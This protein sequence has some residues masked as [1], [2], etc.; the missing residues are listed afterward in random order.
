LFNLVISDVISVHVKAVQSIGVK[1]F[2][3]NTLVF[4][5]CLNHSLLNH[6]LTHFPTRT[7]II[8]GVLQNPVQNVRAFGA[9]K[10]LAKPPI[11]IIFNRDLLTTVVCYIF[12]FTNGP[13]LICPFLLFWLLIWLTSTDIGAIG[14]STDRLNVKESHHFVFAIM[15]LDEL[16]NFLFDAW[17]LGYV[18]DVWAIVLFFAQELLDQQFNVVAGAIRKGVERFVPD[19]VEEASHVFVFKWLAKSNQFVHN[20]SHCPHVSLRVI[21]EVVADLGRHKVWSSTSGFSHIHLTFQGFR[22]TEITKFKDALFDE[23]ILS[24]N[25]TMQDLFAVKSKQRQRYLRSIH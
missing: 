1:L 23:N 9:A 24:F 21:W 16:L 7:F 2:L 4:F 5:N 19:L 25:V 22:D 15:L 6:L 20:N 3:E 11:R 12:K 10:V 17:D 13:S 8:S 18:K 14:T